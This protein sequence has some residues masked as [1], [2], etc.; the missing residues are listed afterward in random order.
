MKYFLSLFAVLAVT[1]SNIALS[2][3]PRLIS[4]QGIIEGSPTKP[5]AGPVELGLRLYTQPD[6]GNP[7]YMENINTEVKNGLFNVYL[8]SGVQGGISPYIDFNR[9][10]WLGVTINGSEELQPRIA[11]ASVPYALAVADSTITPAKINRRSASDENQA[12]VTT[13]NGVEWKGVVTKISGEGPLIVEPYTGIGEVTVRIAVN[14]I[15]GEY[16]APNSLKYDR[17]ST[18]GNPKDGDVLTYIGTPPSGNLQWRA[19]VT[20]PFVLP[21]SGTGDISGQPAF[22]ITNANNGSSAKFA[23]NFAANNSPA[24]IAENNGTGSA[25]AANA[26][27]TGTAATMTIANANSSATVLKA[28]TNGSGAA[29]EGNA[30]NSIAKSNG[31]IGR[32]ASS[33]DSIS[34][35][36]GIITNSAP[37]PSA[38]GVAGKIT[39]ASS[40]GFGVWG[41]H[42]GR[43]IGVM[44]STAQGVGIMGKSRDS[45]GIWGIHSAS[46]GIYPGIYGSTVSVSDTA[47]G[48]TGEIIARASGINSAG[49]KGIHNDTLSNGAGVWGLHNGRGAGVLGST[50]QGIGVR[51]ISRDSIGIAGYHIGASG[52]F[53]GVYGETS[54][55]AQD[56]TG[57]QGTVNNTVPAVGSAGVRGT[58]LGIYSNGYGVYGA[59]AG[60]GIGVYG[61]AS[62]GTGVAGVVQ[63]EEA[64]IG[65]L[66]SSSSAMG[67]GVSAQASASSGKNYGLWASSAS[68]SGIAIY[69]SNTR[70]NSSAYAG[71]FQGKV[72]VT[73]D[74][75]KTYATGVANGERRATPIGYATIKAN[76]ELSAG[77]PNLAC[78]WDASMGAYLITI[79]NENFTETAFTCAVTPISSGTPLIPITSTASNSRLMIKIFTLANATTQNAFQVIIFKP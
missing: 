57:I 36:T 6:G 49:I 42:N 32:T 12:L 17:F 38:S 15:S 62:E 34:G 10:Y 11:L 16:I 47:A 52:R 73:G 74:I 78:N 72:N 59:H 64:T 1:A 71:Y 45:I 46:T 60:K 25:F 28:E 20:T 5:V 7:L 41:S 37:S 19:P 31:I 30:T 35:V 22:T 33:A 63:G 53:A 21:Y 3:V 29:I 66:G 54:A 44:G 13:K 65:V 68:D 51:G 43:G 48:I 70:S 61:T 79:Q 76:G 9:P 69:G 27:G 23:I 26:S 4:V 55:S 8:G 58:N 18:K 40:R 77:T 2:Q 56:A 75:T 39:S 24:L 14:S 67:M 50:T